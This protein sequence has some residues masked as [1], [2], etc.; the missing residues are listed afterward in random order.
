MTHSM[1]INQPLNSEIL[2]VESIWEK[3]VPCK[4]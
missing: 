4:N 3:F 2:A 1:E